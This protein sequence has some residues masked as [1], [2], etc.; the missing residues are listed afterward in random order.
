MRGVKPLP[1]AGQDPKS[2]A[3]AN[4]DTPAWFLIIAEL[5]RNGKLIRFIFVRFY[6]AYKVLHFTSPGMGG[7]S[8][9]GSYF[10][11]GIGSPVYISFFECFGNYFYS[12]IPTL[13]GIFAIG[14]APGII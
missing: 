13:E 7:R 14:P 9:Y 8:V 11:Y 12:L 3:S 1:L 2:C 5:D 6:F 4:S 10:I